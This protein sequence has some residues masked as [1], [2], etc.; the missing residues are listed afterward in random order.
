MFVNRE[1]VARRY[2]QIDPAED[3]SESCE[4]GD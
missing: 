3:C 1:N 4:A 2:Q